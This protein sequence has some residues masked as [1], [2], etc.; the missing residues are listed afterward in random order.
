MERWL[1]NGRESASPGLLCG[2]R[3][4]GGSAPGPAQPSP[5]PGRGYGSG[6]SCAGEAEQL[7]I[8]GAEL[9]HG[10]SGDLDPQEGGGLAERWV[11][12][13]QWWA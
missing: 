13:G 11:G 10:A 2:P 3:Y 7:P 5:S 6:N 4:A 1:A 9:G 12:P 8:R